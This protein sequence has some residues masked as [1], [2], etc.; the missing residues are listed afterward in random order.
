MGV[1]PAGLVAVMIAALAVP[2]A[3]AAQATEHVWRS[4]VEKV[5]VGTEL[6]VRLAGGQRFRA[7]LIEVRDEAVLMLP[8]T[9]VPVPIQP[10]PYREIVALERTRHGMG[11][12]KAAAIGVATG[13]GTVFAILAILFASLDD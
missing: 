13:A 8:K 10:V 1:K 2:P 4:F 6:Q 11:A 5:D 12:G 7:T 9:R 3:F